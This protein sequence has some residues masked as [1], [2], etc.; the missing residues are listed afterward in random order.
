MYTTYNTSDYVPNSKNGYVITSDG[1]IHQIHYKFIH[2]SVIVSLFKE[3]AIQSGISSIELDDSLSPELYK[4]V[5]QMPVV[6][7][8]N[9]GA[10]SVY[11]NKGLTKI[12]INSVEHILKYV[13]GYDGD[14]KVE[15][16]NLT[17]QKTVNE[18]IRKMENEVNLR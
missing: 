5:N 2:N 14:E 6:T 12:Q 3:K 17:K 9:H 4:F 13:Y 18:L 7:I 16:S 11:W 8:S 10:L 15:F 1:L